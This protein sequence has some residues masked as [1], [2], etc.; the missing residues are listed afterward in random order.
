MRKV[1]WEEVRDLCYQISQKIDKLKYNS[2][3][4]IPQGGYPIAIELQKFIDLPIVNEIQ[5]RSLVVDD[6][7][8]SGLTLSRYTQDKAVLFYKKYKDL[9]IQSLNKIIH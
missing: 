1:S 8:D 7:V 5:E 4:E 6:L 9:D 2:I 3:Y